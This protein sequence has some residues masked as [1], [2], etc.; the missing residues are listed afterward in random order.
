[1]GE[2]GFPMNSFDLAVYLVL[3]VAVVAGFR[4]G[5]LRSSVT[6]LGYLFRSES[7]D[8]SD[9]E[10]VLFITPTVIAHTS[11][12]NARRIE[13]ALKRYEDYEGTVVY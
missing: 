10:N 8:S 2:T 13:D 4:A 12:D 3:V 5:L 9:T 6:I 7:G 1:M 11:P